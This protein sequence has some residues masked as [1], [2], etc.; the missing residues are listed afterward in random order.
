VTARTR[1]QTRP[2]RC[3][4]C[5]SAFAARRAH[6]G[7]W[8]RTCSPRCQARALEK[9]IAAL[10]ARRRTLLLEELDA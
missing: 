8:T 2:A 7:R 6:N 5:G 3:A 10:E 4:S 9:L 1:P